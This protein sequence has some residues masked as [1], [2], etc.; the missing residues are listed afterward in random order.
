VGA[1]RFCIN[2]NYYG[3]DTPYCRAKKGE[4]GANSN[5]G[6]YECGAINHFR[7]DCPKLKNQNAK[8]RAFE[9]NTKEARQEPSVVTGTFLINNN[10]ASVLFDTGADMSFVSKDF[11][12]LL[13]M[14]SNKLRNRYVIE[15]ANGKKIEAE[16]VIRG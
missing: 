16:N 12:S 15:L 2:S 1:C 10:Y 9:M 5:R 7:K 8:G 11:E 3:H 14:Q 13:G 6:C 4:K